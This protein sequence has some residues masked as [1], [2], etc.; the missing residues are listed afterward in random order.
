MATSLDG[1]VTGLND[2]SFDKNRVNKSQSSDRAVGG[3]LG[4][5]E[6]LQLLVCQMK[7]QDPL[8][9]EKDTQFIAQ[10][11]QFSALEQMQNHRRL[12]WLVKPLFLIQRVQMEVLPKYRV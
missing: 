10:L 7:N 2:L 4:K 9:P 6:F 5:D 12:D 8:E 11:A 1:I 3:E